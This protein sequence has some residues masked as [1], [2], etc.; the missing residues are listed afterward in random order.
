[1]GNPLSGVN[2]TFNING[3]FYTRLTNESGYANL[4]LRLQPGKYIVTAEYNSL[5]Y[6]NNVTILQVMFANDTVSYKTTNFTVK[7]IDGQGNPYANQNITFNI[8]GVRYTN[9]TGEDGI[10]HLIVKLPAGEYIVTSSYD[11]YN[12]NNRIT[13]RNEV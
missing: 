1:M 3:V 13:V 5:K 11:E 8:N 4:N 7:L 6:S 12:I 2:V 9:V 10:A